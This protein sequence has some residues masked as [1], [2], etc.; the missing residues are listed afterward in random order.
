MDPAD[1]TVIVEAVDQDGR[2][3]FGAA[4]AP[5]DVVTGFLAMKTAHPWSRSIGDTPIGQDPVETAA[6]RDL[7]GKQ[8]GIPADAPMGGVRRHGGG[9]G[10]RVGAGRGYPNG[11]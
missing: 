7:A 11:R 10:L 3:G 6:P 2:Y 8:R 9:A 4:D 5:A 1:Q